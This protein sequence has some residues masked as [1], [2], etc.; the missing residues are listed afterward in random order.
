MASNSNEKQKDK[1]LL[2]IN[3]QKDKIGNALS[4]LKESLAMIQEGNK[5]QPYWNGE[6]AYS[7]IS[8]LLSY[9]DNGYELLDRIDE[10][11]KELKNNR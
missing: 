1:I 9:V 2:N 4:S 7:I 5:D 8:Q 11:Q 3:V 10:C 6:N